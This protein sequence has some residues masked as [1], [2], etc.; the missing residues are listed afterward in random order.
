MQVVFIMEYLEGGEL[1]EYLYGTNSF[2]T[3]T[4]ASYQRKRL[5]Y[6]SYRLLRRCSTAINGNLSIGT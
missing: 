5:E 4:V 1:L 2:V 3:K 6:F